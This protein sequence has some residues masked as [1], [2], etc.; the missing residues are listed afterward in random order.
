[1]NKL[2]PC[3][4]LLSIFFN[5]CGNRSRNG[6]KF[7]EN[8]VETIKTPL[9]KELTGAQLSRSYCSSC[10]LYPEPSLLD[11]ETWENYILPLMGNFYGIYV[12]DTTRQFLIEGGRAGQFVEKMNIF[13]REPTIDTA[14]FNKIKRYY[15]K[16]A[17]EKLPKAPSKNIKVGLKDFKVKR[18]SNKTKN[19]MTALVKVSAPNEIYISDVGRSTLSIMDKN[20]NVL[21]TAPSPE[22][23]VW[24]KKHK[25][26]TYALVIG[27]FNP[28]DMNLGYVMELPS[29]PGQVTKIPIKDLQRPVHLDVGDLDGDGLEDMVI[30]E[31]GKHTGSLS[32]WK[33]EM[34]G[35]YS[36]KVLKNKPGATKAYI[37]DLNENGKNDII[38]LMGQGDE[39]IFIFH[40][41]G[42]SNFI[43]EKV[44]GF[45]AVYGSSYFE[46]Y[47]FNGDG[48]DDII[49]TAGDNADYDPIIKDYHGIRVFINDG[50]NHFKEEF[51][52]QLNG[53]YKAVP[54]DFD[55][56]GDIDIAAI[57]FFP[58][59]ESSPEES[60][61]YLE[62]KG[63][64]KFE[65][66]TFEGSS[67][68]RWMVMD[69][70]DTDGDGDM[71][72]I[73]GSMVFGTDFTRYFDQWVEGNL[74]FVL[75][76]NRL[77]K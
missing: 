49:Y 6:D 52:Y 59:Y 70:G 32:W 68:G 74:P 11:R 19:P 26:A 16:E 69:V 62:N 61:V 77:V 12:S 54:F 29:K 41:Q 27:T 53:A 33:Q 25:N 50:S 35:Q 7:E 28:T 15:L 45:P 47:D 72:I 55:G 18:P 9:Q 4:L 63:D 75:L 37:R 14:I 21:K 36:K 13:P 64:L 39:G 42:N 46:L 67:E 65:A 44:L 76:E 23:T 22:G 71:D 30:C 48:H 60:F 51:F 57:S 66:Y 40:N 58:D 73:L 10:H 2:I 38:A 34:G 8:S 20:M 1:M 17:P 24:I 43:E 56:D 5:S 31:Y 3:L